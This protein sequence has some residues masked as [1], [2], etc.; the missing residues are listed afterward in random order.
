MSH[1]DERE[2]KLMLRTNYISGIVTLFCSV[3]LLLILIGIEKLP[4]QRTVITVS[5]SLMGI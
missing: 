2:W 4:S 5:A 1:N 3:G